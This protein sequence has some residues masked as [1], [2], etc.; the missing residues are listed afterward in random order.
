[1]VG[2][3]QVNRMKIGPAKITELSRE[4]RDSYQDATNHNVKVEPYPQASPG[5]VTPPTG[6]PW[7]ASE[8]S[9]TLTR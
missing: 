4:K 3:A 9:R 7:L 6:V 1:M 2:R 8:V 5:V